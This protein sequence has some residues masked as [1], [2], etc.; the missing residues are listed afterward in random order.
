[1]GLLL[2]RGGCVD[3]A[4]ARLLVV[5]FAEFWVCDFV[6]LDIGLWFSYCV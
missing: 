3:V 2:F 6:Y 1:M 4:L 5:G